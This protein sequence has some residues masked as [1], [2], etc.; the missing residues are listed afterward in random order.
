MNG[1]NRLTRVTWD[2][3]TAALPASRSNGKP[4]DNFSITPDNI[5]GIV[6]E[7]FQ[8]WPDKRAVYLLTTFVKYMHAY[9]RETRL[10]HAEWK[11]AMDY[12]HD[13]GLTG[14]EHTEEFILTSDILGITAMVDMLESQGSSATPAS[15]LGP[16]YRKTAEVIPYGGDMIKANQGIPLVCRGTIKNLKG[17]PIPNALIEV[18]QNHANGLYSGED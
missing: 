7:S 5:T 18:W 15:I 6:N 9:V 14:G 12:L 17:E 1:E 16:F 3:S 8:S 13:T 10:N 4:S 11:Y 2:E